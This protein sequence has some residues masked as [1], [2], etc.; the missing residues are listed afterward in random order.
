MINAKE[1]YIVGD[2]VETPI[3]ECD[4]IKVRDYPNYFMDLQVIS[5]SKSQIYYKY[6]QLN[7]D[8]S[9]NEFLE[10]LNK[11]NLYQSVINIPELQQAYLNIFIKVFNDEE[12][13]KQIDE[14]NFEDYRKLVMDMNCLK[15]EKVNPNP[16]IQRA[17]ERSR[18]VKSQDGEP[19]EFSDIASSIVAFSGK[20]YKDLGDMTIYQFYMTYHRIAQF[21]NYDTST[22][23]ATVSA[24]KVNIESWSKH[25][26]LFAEEKHFVSEQEF[27]KNT[28][29]VFD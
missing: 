3:G 4:F 5:W 13:V 12:I 16:E 11:L 26:D 2:P 27:K 25:I 24:D 9:L 29:S 15:E 6:S 22:L 20:S 14:S 17:I 21:K 28:G 18:R 8:G 1:F 10:E 7:K 19:L 23:F